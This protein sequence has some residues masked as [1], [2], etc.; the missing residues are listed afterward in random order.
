MEKLKGGLSYA[1]EV[2]LN[3]PLYNLFELI[4]HIKNAWI[5]LMER[6]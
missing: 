6:T 1:P 4:P 5:S 3:K 2:L